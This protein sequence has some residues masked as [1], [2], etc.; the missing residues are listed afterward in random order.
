MS[1]YKKFNRLSIN[2]K[3]KRSTVRENGETKTLVLEVPTFVSPTNIYVP[4]LLISN[5][6]DINHNNENNNE[7]NNSSKSILPTTNSSFNRINSNVNK[8]NNNT[9]NYPLE[10]KE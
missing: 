8:Y 2:R 9:I 5:S 1:F 6:V 4:D 7:S 10:D 3:N